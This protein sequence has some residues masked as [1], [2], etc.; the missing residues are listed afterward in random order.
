MTTTAATTSSRA[1]RPSC[2]AP[3]MLDLP[4]L[5]GGVPSSRQAY[6]SGFTGNRAACRRLM[7]PLGGR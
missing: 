2:R 4:P 3:P 1:R 6:P 5:T 7:N